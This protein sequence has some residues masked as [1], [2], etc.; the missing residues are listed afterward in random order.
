MRF[1][2]L[3]SAITGS[4]CSQN[5]S[6]FQGKVIRRDT[7]LSR[8]TLSSFLLILFQK[9]WSHFSETEPE[10]G[11]REKVRH[12]KVSLGRGRPFHKIMAE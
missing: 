4:F 8:P 6:K 3:E 12:K 5:F 11:E 2:L 9:E 1:S 10:K 7:S